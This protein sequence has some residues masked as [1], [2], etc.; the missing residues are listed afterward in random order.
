MVISELKRM[1]ISLLLLIVFTGCTLGDKDLKIIPLKKYGCKI[2]LKRVSWL[3]DNSRTYISNNDNWNDTVNEPYFTSLDFFC[4]L[5]T[6]NC[7]LIIY[8]SDSLRRNNRLRVPIVLYEKN[9]VDY[10]NYKQKGFD[11]ILYQ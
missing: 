8:K 2:F 6:I 5:D 1:K 9:D 4:K 10:Q 7:K 11:N 3:T